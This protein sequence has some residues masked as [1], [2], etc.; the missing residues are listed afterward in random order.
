MQFPKFQLKRPDLHFHASGKLTPLIIAC[1]FI[2]VVL[3]YAGAEVPGAWAL[4][5]AILIGLAEQRKEWFE[6]NGKHQYSLLFVAA[7]AP[8]VVIGILAGF[9]PS[10]TGWGALLLV[11]GAGLH[12][13]SHEKKRSEENQKQIED[14][15]QSGQDVAEAQQ[16]PGE[17]GNNENN[18]KI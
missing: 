8:A 1:V 17:A 5:L 10:L 7:G 13:V 18:N 11:L 9:I 4:Y 16:K 2:G 14:A 6:K 3:V 15:I 12:F